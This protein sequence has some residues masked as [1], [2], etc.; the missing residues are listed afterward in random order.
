VPEVDV[1]DGSGLVGFITAG[2]FCFG[3]VP[4]VE[5]VGGECG[6]LEEDEPLELAVGGVNGAGGSA[7]GATGAGG[8]WAAEGVGGAPTVGPNGWSLGIDVQLYWN[9]GTVS[10][11]PVRNL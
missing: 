2:W 11:S 1:P 10:S 6:E 4:N 5:G 9:S 7:G 3:C 8:A